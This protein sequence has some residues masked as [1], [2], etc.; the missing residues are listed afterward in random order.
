MPT[1]RQEAIDIVRNGLGGLISC[2]A[3]EYAGPRPIIRNTG[4]HQYELWVCEGK[5][6]TF[7]NVGL[8]VKQASLFQ[9]LLSTAT[10][11]IL[12][13]DPVQSRSSSWTALPE[14]AGHST[15]SR[16]PGV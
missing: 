14:S 4:G 8:W 10:M 13:L 2:L 1:E 12:S 7:Y 6:K 15:V 5:G 3:A 11:F 16:P 9:Y